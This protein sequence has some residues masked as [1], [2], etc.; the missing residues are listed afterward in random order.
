MAFY[1]LE[2]IWYAPYP[3]PTSLMTPELSNSAMMCK[4]SNVY[5]SVSSLLQFKDI[6]FI[7][8]PYCTT[9]KKCEKYQ[10]GNNN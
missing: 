3:L 4:L 1:V 5:Y 8:T 9:C 7:M 2:Y 6:L 10:L